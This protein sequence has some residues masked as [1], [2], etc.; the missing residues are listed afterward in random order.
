MHREPEVEYYPS[1]QGVDTRWHTYTGVKPLFLKKQTKGQKA[2]GFQ[3]AGWILVQ[4]S[5]MY[6]N[7]NCQEV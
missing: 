7:S 3:P 2:L 5:V 4:R 6:T 1:G